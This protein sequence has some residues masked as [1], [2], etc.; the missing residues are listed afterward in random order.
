M[1]IEFPEAHNGEKQ[2][3]PHNRSAG[4]VFPEMIILKFGVSYDSKGDHRKSSILQQES[5]R[6]EKSLSALLVIT[7]SATASQFQNSK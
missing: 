2:T 6:D 1:L 7:I 5:G 4:W 3:D